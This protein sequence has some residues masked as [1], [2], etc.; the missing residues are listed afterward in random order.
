VIV[1]RAKDAGVLRADVEPSDLVL[2]T[3][4]IA[5]TAD[6]A[7]DTARTPGGGTWAPA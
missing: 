4:G 2:F 1:A 6:A 5:V 3:W 7:R